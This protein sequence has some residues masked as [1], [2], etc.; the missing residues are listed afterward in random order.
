MKNKALGRK[1]GNEAS[2]SNGSDAQVTSDTGQK[3][4]IMILM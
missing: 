2:H 3:V 1:N 4:M